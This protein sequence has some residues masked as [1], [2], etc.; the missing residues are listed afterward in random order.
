MVAKY[1]DVYIAPYTGASEL[2][3]MAC[4]WSTVVQ[5]AGTRKDVGKRDGETVT[6]ATSSGPSYICGPP[7]PP[8]N[9]PK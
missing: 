3:D 6:I 7:C 5:L 4:T 9:G 2:A 8:P 1:N